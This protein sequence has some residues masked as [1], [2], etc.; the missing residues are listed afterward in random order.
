MLLMG[1]LNLPVSDI[2]FVFQRPKSHYGT[3][4]ER[5]CIKTNST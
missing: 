5:R 1:A 3:G 2:E 4:K